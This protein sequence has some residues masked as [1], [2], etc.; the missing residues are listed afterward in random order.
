MDR[1]GIT[2]RVE[3]KHLT[4][5]NWQ[6]LPLPMSY[7]DVSRMGYRSANAAGPAFHRGSFELS[8][9]V[10]GDTFLDVGGWSMGC[11]WVNGHHLGRFWNVGPQQTLYCPGCWLRSGPNEIIVFDLESTGRQRIAGLDEPILDQFRLPSSAS[12][13]R[14]SS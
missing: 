4:L 2:E 13:P 11:V 3:L 14:N 12:S 10:I 9:A 8:E 1:K 6:V 7:R 5:S